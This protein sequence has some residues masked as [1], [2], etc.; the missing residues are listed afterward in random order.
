MLTATAEEHD[1]NKNNYQHVGQSISFLQSIG[2][3]AMAPASVSGL[4]M[5]WRCSYS[6]YMS[7]NVTSWLHRQ[8]LA[9]T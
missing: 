8:V 9:A 6:S 3:L 1:N 4:A 2:S 7:L 5:P